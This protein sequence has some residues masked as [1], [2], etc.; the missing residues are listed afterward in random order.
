[1][2]RKRG[3]DTVTVER[4]PETSDFNWEFRGVERA[5]PNAAPAEPYV[6]TAS[7]SGSS[8]PPAS[9]STSSNPFQAPP[10]A[11]SSRKLYNPAYCGSFE[12]FLRF[13]LVSEEDRVTRAGLKKG[14][15]TNW[16]SLQPCDEVTPAHLVADGVP[17]GIAAALIRF[18]REFLAHVQECIRRG[19]WFVPE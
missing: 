12:D 14:G 11:T 3:T 9:T 16:A 1:M 13:A 7:G 5:H 8:A 15:Y 19:A 2:C 10:P 17:H 4:P 18:A 6:P